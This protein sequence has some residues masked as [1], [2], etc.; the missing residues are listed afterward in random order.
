MTR[1]PSFFSALSLLLAASAARA[2]A[3]SLAALS[4]AEVPEGGRVVL[5]G[6]GFGALSPASRVEVG[7]ARVPFARW[8]DT[9]VVAWVGEGVAAG[10]TTVRVVNADGASASLPLRVTPAARVSER[11][12]WT[13]E[14][15]GGSPRHRPT[16]APDGTVYVGDSAGYVYAVSR[17]GRLRWVYDSARA[18]GATAARANG[19]PIARGADG[20]LYVPVMPLGPTPEVHALAP[21]GT[22]RWIH[23]SEA[24]GWTVAGPA[25]GP[26]G[27]VY[28]VRVG[29]VVEAISPEGVTR[30]MRAAE[31]SGASRSDVYG[32]EIVFGPSRPGG[33]VDRFYAALYQRYRVFPGPIDVDQLLYGFD[34]D[35][36]VRMRAPTGGL[37]AAFG[38]RQG[39]PAVGPDGA[40]HVSGLVIPHGWSAQSFAPEDGARRWIWTGSPANTV[41]EPDVG[42]DGTV[43]VTHNGHAVVAIGPDGAQRWRHTLGGQSSGPVA[44]PGGDSVLTIGSEGESRRLVVTSVDAR[45]GALRWRAEVPPREGREHLEAA[46]LSF[47]PRGDRAYA[48]TS[49]WGAN[50]DPTPWTLVAIDLG[51]CAATDAG[52]TPASDAGTTDAGVTDAGV[53][54]ASVTDASVTDAGVADAG[55]DVVDGGAVPERAVDSGGG[56]GCSATPTGTR[57]GAG[58]AAWLGLLGVAVARRRGSRRRP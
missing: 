13:F 30:W 36:N 1:C 17:E 15:D 57:G 44:R 51:D 21:D 37:S 8:T 6:A 40:V 32:E 33:P 27:D 9:V 52:C 22:L 55:A 5:S 53:T 10:E 4:R 3:P 20:T 23:R 16:V 42:P 2:E 56:V 26:N 11:V 25:V 18:T 50:T 48:V 45:D 41:S 7:G 12:A 58:V 49:L 28:V 46:R 38:Q 39:Q 24:Q 29:V 43:Y 47:D 34:L 54:D 31:P 19:G 14:T 35:G